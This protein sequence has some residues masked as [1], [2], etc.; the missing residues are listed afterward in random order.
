MNAHKIY[1]ALHMTCR[2][3]SQP[4]IKNVL[5]CFNWKLH[6]S[7]PPIFMGSYV[8]TLHTKT[9]YPLL[10]IKKKIYILWTNGSLGNQK[11]YGILLTLLQKSHLKTF[12]KEWMDVLMSWI[13]I[14]FNN[15]MGCETIFDVRFKSYFSSCFDILLG[16]M[17][18]GAHNKM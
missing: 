9:L 2:Y 10:H 16:I 14:W 18:T 17:C 12:I 1:R 6:F 13:L 3:L 5:P 8:P 4:R 15:E 11:I 7:G